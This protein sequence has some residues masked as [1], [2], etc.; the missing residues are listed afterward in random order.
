MRFFI[1]TIGTKIKLLDDWSFTLYNE[2]RN[3]TLKTAFGIVGHPNRWQNNPITMATYNAILIA[4]TVMSVDRIYIRKNAK[5]FDSIT[6]K[7]LSSSDERLQKKQGS[8]G[9]GRFWVKLDDANNINA[10]IVT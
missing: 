5:E 10:D 7:I 8:H 3:I 4:G 6:F 9:Y 2:Y 1:P